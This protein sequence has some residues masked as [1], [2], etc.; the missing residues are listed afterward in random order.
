MNIIYSASG[1][2]TIL[3]VVLLLSKKQKSLAD[4][5]LSLWFLLILLAIITVYYSHNNLPAWQGFFELTDSSV[6]L[7]G[8]MIWFYTRSLTEDGF[9]FKKKDILHFL[10]FLIGAIFLFSPLIAGEKVSD[11]RRNIVLV[12]KMTHLLIYGLAVLWRLDWHKKNIVNYFSYTEKIKLNWLQLLVWSLLIIWL[13]SVVSQLLY[14]FGGLDIPQYGGYFT[15]LAISLFVLV[16]GYFGIRQTTI[17]LPVHLIENTIKNDISVQQEVLTIEKSEELSQD[18]HSDQKDVKVDKRFKQL[19]NFMEVEKPF[20]DGQ[21]TL[22]KLASQ[23]ELP[24]HQ[25][26]RLIN[27][28][29][30]TNFFDF[31][32]QYRVK[33]VQNK[34]HQQAH[35]RQ[36]LLA[37]ALDSGFNSKASFNRVFKKITGQTPKEYV[38]G[39]T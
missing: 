19:L 20:L 32:N 12:I 13:I 22:V 28:Y 15:N 16:T 39:V 33:E 8:P 37:I 5:I 10:P 31:V 9:S 7:H 18:T 25:L 21:L 34:I 6:F 17:F 24:P 35:V 36:T 29:G 30:G 11:L 14:A 1:V 26:S 23:L 2:L 4:Y 27:Q 3:F 38:Q